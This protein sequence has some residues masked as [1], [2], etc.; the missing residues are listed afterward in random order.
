MQASVSG[1]RV[2]VR[3][4]IAPGIASAGAGSGST[5]QGVGRALH[6]NFEPEVEESVAYGYLVTYVDDVLILAPDLVSDK[7][8][9]VAENKWNITE[10]PTVAFGSG[11]SVEYPSVNIAAKDSDEW[12]GKEREL[13]TA[14]SAHIK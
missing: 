5:P 1:V 3:G 7:P 4:D 11:H 9:T 10:K 2:I 8:K 13:A 12:F 14:Y 6:S